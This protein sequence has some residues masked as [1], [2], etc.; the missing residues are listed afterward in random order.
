[1]STCGPSAYAGRMSHK[2]K[3][4]DFAA[5]FSAQRAEAEAQLWRYMEARGLRAADGWRLHETTRDARQ[6]TELVIRPIHRVHGCP[7]GLECIVWVKG[8]DGTIDIRCSSD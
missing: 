4:T 5:R 8:D 2:D 1:M 7:P 6:G 3:D